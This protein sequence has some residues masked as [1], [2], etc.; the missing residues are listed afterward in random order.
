MAHLSS[1]LESVEN[2]MPFRIVGSVQSISGLTIEASDLPLPLGSLC[3]INSFGGRTAT[4][5]VIGFQ[6]DRT[7]L[8][9][10][11]TT[12]GA[13]RGDRI[14]NLTSAPRIGCS[15]QLLGRVVNGFGKPIDGKGTLNITESRRI[16][17]AAVLATGRGN[18]STA[19]RTSIPPCD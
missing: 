11:S 12:T 4:A 5:E 7:L 3:R 18:I 17:S 6:N 16:D 9:P 19:I 10:L 13:A 15:D 8:M 14:E 2:S 1:H